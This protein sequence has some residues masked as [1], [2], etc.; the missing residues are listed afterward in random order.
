MRIEA[1]LL[2]CA[3][4]FAPDLASAQARA[5]SP[6]AGVPSPSGS[7]PSELDR[8][9]PIS[10]VEAVALG[11]R[12]NRDFRAAFLD[13]AVQR[14]RLHAAEQRFAPRLD[15]L[16]D[17]YR[18]DSAGVVTHQASVSGVGTMLL[19][20]GA[21][22]GFVWDRRQRLDRRGDSDVATLTVAQPLLR[23]GGFAVNRA[24]LRIARLQD[25]IEQ[26]A[27]RNTLSEGISRIVFAY[28][29]LQ[30]A[31]EQVRLAEL[32]LARTAELIATNR[33]LIDA[34]RMAA[35]D[36]VQSEADQANQQVAL[37]QMRQQRNSSQLALLQQLALDPSTNIVAADPIAAEQVPIDMR[38]AIEIARSRRMDL[39]AQQHAVEQAREGLRIARNQRLWDLSLVGTATRTAG[40]DPVFG[41]LPSLAN[42]RVGLQ[43]A[44]PLGDPAPGL[45]VA[46]ADT[47]LRTAELRLES[48]D[49]SVETQV[50]D[51]GQRVEAAWLQVEASR[52][53]KGLSA[54]A[55][56]I[57]R[58]KLAAGRSSN[59]EVLSLQDSLR[60]AEIQELSSIIS[61]LDALTSFDLQIGATLESWKIEGTGA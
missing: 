27:L 50:R 31:Q 1:A 16:A 61:Y 29:A 13:R 6:I 39:L 4:L 26:L 25:A 52:R 41:P 23:G 53:S 21:R 12:D 55:V 24:P 51:A 19:P 59:F 28:H 56:D 45:A 10:L 49:Q 15:I 18:D 40:R 36:I 47:S 3:L 20:S 30:Q 17:V 32:A 44:I 9:V 8:P 33:A 60:T 58:D 43:L 5:M 34:G 38:Q 37:Q 7:R 35:A 48:L 57:A 46:E 22:V 42:N 2:G 14:F 11:V 54:R